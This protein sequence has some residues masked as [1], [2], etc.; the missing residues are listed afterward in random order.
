MSEKTN[1]DVFVSYS[2]KNKNVA[3]AIVAEFEKN[4]IRCWYAPRDITPGDSWVSAITEALQ[5][6][7]VQV[8]VYTDESNASRQVMNEVAVAFNAG[9][10]IVPFR[11]TEAKMSSEFEYYLSRVHW[12]DAIAPPLNDNI[13][14]LRQYVEV[15][16]AGIDKV[17]AAGTDTAAPHIHP[18]PA[19]QPAQ[20]SQYS[21]SSQS[22]QLGQSSQP[23]QSSQSMQPAQSRKQLTPRFVIGI[24]VA[25]LVLI[26]VIVVLSMRALY[27]GYSRQVAITDGTGREVVIKTEPEKESTG[28]DVSD[29]KSAEDKNGEAEDAGDKTTEDITSEGGNTEDKATE[30]DSTEDKSTEDGTSEAG[31]NEDKS[32]EDGNAEDKVTEDG[33]TEDKAPDGGNA[34][35]T[36]DTG[37]TKDTGDTAAD[38]SESAENTDRKDNAAEIDKKDNTDTT[39]KDDKSSNSTEEKDVSDMTVEEL[40]RAAKK[41]DVAA[42]DE[43]GAMYY[44]GEGVDQDY[45]KALLYLSR[46]DENN[47]KSAETYKRL[48]DIYYYGKGVDLSDETAGKYYGK[49]VDLGIKDADV[50][51]NYGMVLYRDDRFADSAKYFANA[52]KS[53]KDPMTMYNAGLAYYGAE[54]YDNALT[55]F[56]KA[57]DSGY[58]RPDDAR[59]QI[60]SMV[61]AG[62]VSEKAAK[63]WL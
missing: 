45:G 34:E 28:T 47:T 20:S 39:D 3:D 6:V 4:G 19:I 31:D 33:N 38:N 10:T 49:A 1:A 40:E 29:R 35:N 62:L 25:L 18:M 54:D 36:S 16:L 57:I 43:L 30:G 60:R 32:A 58:S 7:K 55:W 13:S 56:G 9:K 61:D 23:G 15:I 41:G 42:C 59:S 26:P 37:N 11:L 44:N 8:L 24:C 46:A 53:N 2:S 14:Q 5:S 27:S 12:L 51:S 21:Q 50:W 52:A 22:S 48:G 17:Y 63:K